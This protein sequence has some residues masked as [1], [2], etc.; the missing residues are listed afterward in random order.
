MA[1]IAKP[2]DQL[3][4]PPRKDKVRGRWAPLYIEPMIGSGER[5]AIGVAVAADGNFLVVPVPA[6]ERL[7]C[8][9]GTENEA[10]L[11]AAR[12]AL[13]SMQ[14]VLA[15]SGPNGLDSWSSPFDGIF[16]GAI[17]IGAGNSMGEIARSALTLC[18]SLVEK[19]AD[20][21]EVDEPRAAISESRLEKLIKERVVAARPGL[22]QAFGRKFQAHPK[23]RAAKVGFVGQRIAAN[24]SLLAPPY[25][26]RQVK[27]AKAK[28][29]DLAQVQEYLHAK[30]FNLSP[31]I[32]RFELLIHRVRDDDPQYSDQQILQVQ[33]A[34]Y[35]LEAEADKKEIRCRPLLSTD[36]IAGIIVEAEAA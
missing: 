24:F 19:I 35:E 11:F 34:V 10:L 13:D 4:F 12:S 18:S 28:L 23:A 7:S 27:D 20:A 8:I 30:E 9:Y 16:K 36:E 6:L 5:L 32:N 2:N 31:N 3:A 17:R 26:S 29:W 22:E 33:E 1:Q 25:V 15:K 21:D 14:G